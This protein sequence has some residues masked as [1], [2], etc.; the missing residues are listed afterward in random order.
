MDTFLVD[1]LF[2]ISCISFLLGHISEQCDS[3]PQII[4]KVG[5]FDP[6]GVTEV[7]TDLPEEL[8]GIPFGR[9]GPRIQYMVRVN[10]GF[11]FCLSFPVR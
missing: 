10:Y 2:Y 6:Q 9:L 8:S 7:S 5:L 4:V 3:G 11:T 1:L